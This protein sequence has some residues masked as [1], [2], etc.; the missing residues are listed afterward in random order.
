[1]ANQQPKLTVFW[2]SGSPFAWRVLLA[3]EF[4]KLP[5]ESRL[6]EFSKGDPKAPEY[7]ALNPRGKVPTLRHGD[8]VVRES[9]AILAYLE[10]AFPQPAIFGETAAETGR[11]WQ[12]I[13][14]FMS[15]LGDP[16]N[17]VIRPLV[18]G[19]AAEKADDVREAAKAAHEEFAMLERARANGRWLAGATLSAADI[20]IYPFFKLLL[21]VAA[22]DEAKPLD[23]GLLPFEGR[24]PKLAGWIKSVETI[25][26]YAR[27]YPPHW[28]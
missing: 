3:L 12:T 28:K 25:P 20:A 22:R 8:V 13:A 6:L 16:L 9:L 10:R 2:G 7:L 19:E 4:K 23:L 1:M 11:I 17:R 24:Y 21:R 14:E 18:F 15:Y 5:Y 26:G 27:T